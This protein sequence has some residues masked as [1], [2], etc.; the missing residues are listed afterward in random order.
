MR[1]ILLGAMLLACTSQRSD[2]TGKQPQTTATGPP[3]DKTTRSGP[4]VARVSLVPAS[5]R[6]GDPLRLDLVVEA[7]A[8]VVV[9]MPPFGEA[10]GRFLITSFT[11]RQEQLPDGKT[12]HV[13]SYLLEAPMSGRQR[14]PPLRIGFSDRRSGSSGSPDGSGGDHELL[15]EEIAVE[16]ASALPE[17]EVAA[18][19]R[20]LREALP[21]TPGV[22]VRWYHVTGGTLVVLLLGGWRL[23]QYLRQR[24]AR[25]ARAA[26]HEIALERLLRLER[27]GFPGAAEADAWYVELSDAVR[28]YIEDRYG[29][30]APELT[31]EEFLRE[32]QHLPGMAASHREQLAVFLGTCDRV[33]FAAYHPAPEESRVALEQARTFVCETRLA[34]GKEGAA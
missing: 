29:V 34:D 11:P 16:I 7:E 8:G 21:E 15:T 18:E 26:A 33:K 17:G 30:R 27:R 28:R 13:Q 25:R 6:I 24:A 23:R 4:V 14:I 20:G 12:R 2:G 32:A 1:W 31:T 10:L 9:E 3:I 5:A 22:R 19:L